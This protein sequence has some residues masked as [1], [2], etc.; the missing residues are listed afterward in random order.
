MEL[1][2]CLVAT[3]LHWIPQ[4]PDLNR[5]YVYFDWDEITKETGPV[6]LNRVSSPFARPVWRP[7][8]K[9]NFLTFFA[10][11]AECSF[12]ISAHHHSPKILHRLLVDK[13]CGCVGG[14][15]GVFLSIVNLPVAL[16]SVLRGGRLKRGPSRSKEAVTMSP[17]REEGAVVCCVCS[18]LFPYT[19][20]RGSAT[21]S[22][23]LCL[24]GWLAGFLD[25]TGGI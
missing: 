2:N 5:C 22:V 19:R 11:S 10:W 13:S 9:H 17:R 18:C 8:C 16:S 4:T 21:S 23:A 6:V 12:A 7:A 20:K 1:I 3:T 24:S 14:G 25:L 15:G